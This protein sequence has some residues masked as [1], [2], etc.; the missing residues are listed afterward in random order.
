MCFPCSTLNP[1]SRHLTLDPQANGGAATGK[2][3]SFSPPSHH[4]SLSNLLTFFFQSILSSMLTP[5]ARE[6]RACALTAPAAGCPPPLTRCLCSR[7]HRARQGRQGPQGR[8]SSHHECTARCCITLPFCHSCH[9]CT[10]VIQGKVDETQLKAMLEQIN[11]KTEQKV[12][13]SRTRTLQQQALST[14]TL[15]RSLLPAA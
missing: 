8:G 1:I 4:L 15:R 12:K 6:R 10:G 5:A 11:E 2:R 14:F 7:Q 3:R 9:C 13:V